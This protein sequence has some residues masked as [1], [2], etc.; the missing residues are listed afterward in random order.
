MADNVVN[1]NRFRKKKAREDRAKQAEENRV[2]HGRTQAQKDLERLE[3]ARAERLLAGKRMDATAHRGTRHLVCALDF[4]GRAD[5]EKV[6]ARISSLLQAFAPSEGLTVRA[7]RGTKREVLPTRFRPTAQVSA[8]Q[9]ARG[10]TLEL[11]YPLVEP[12]PGR[13]TNPVFWVASEPARIEDFEDAEEDEDAPP[14]LR[15][16]MC[17]ERPA[18]ARAEAAITEALRTFV[19]ACVVLEGCISAILTTQEPPA[20]LASPALAYELFAGTDEEARRAAWL[21]AHV[22]APGWL[23]L[24]PG[25]VTEALPD[26]PPEGLAIERVRAG[27][28]AH[29]EAAETPFAT[30]GAETMET[31]LGALLRG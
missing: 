29:R 28:L 7:A 15:F 25:E 20:S 30:A 3:R 27:V 21:R 17:L 31:W 4:D 10:G 23:V 11:G 12:A 22:R 2:R 16:G 13:C 19:E 14:A 8:A 5:L 1:L 18:S 26:P 24:V 6:A 9:L